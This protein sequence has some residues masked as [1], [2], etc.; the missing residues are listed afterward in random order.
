[1]VILGVPNDLDSFI[2]VDDIEGF[3]LQQLGFHP[4]YRDGEMLYFKRAKKIL[5]A[6]QNLNL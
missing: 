3:E 5:K 1:M 2:M 4:M 6:I